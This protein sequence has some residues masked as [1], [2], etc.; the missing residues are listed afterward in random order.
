MFS[1][2]P[3]T[4]TCVSTAIE[5]PNFDFG[6]AARKDIQHVKNFIREFVLLV[7]VH[8]FQFNIRPMKVV[9]H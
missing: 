6:P 5:R 8:T 4:W 9:T 2:F 7:P 1:P 3:L